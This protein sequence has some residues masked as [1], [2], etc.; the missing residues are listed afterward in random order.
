[1]IRETN[2]NMDPICLQYRG[3]LLPL[4]FA[5]S[6]YDEPLRKPPL[7]IW[8]IRSFKDIPELEFV[9]RLERRW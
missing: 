6:P 4:I 5:Q 1:M 9:G 7:P 3:R 8:R 2:H